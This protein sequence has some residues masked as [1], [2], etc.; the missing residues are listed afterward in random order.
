MN[1]EECWPNTRDT[2]FLTVEFGR[3]IQQ[4]HGVYLGIVDIGYSQFVKLGGRDGNIGLFA[5]DR[6]VAVSTMVK[7]LPWRND[8]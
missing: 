7:Q 2:V 8:A 1:V 3:E 6:I 4:Y 5:V